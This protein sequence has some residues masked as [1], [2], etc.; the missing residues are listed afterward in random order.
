MTFLNLSLGS[1]AVIGIVVGLLGIA[2]VE[3]FWPER[4][5]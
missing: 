3:V 1:L 4:A 5:R 2:T